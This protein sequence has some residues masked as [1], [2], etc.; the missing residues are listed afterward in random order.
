MIT[1]AIGA[2]KPLTVCIAAEAREN[3]ELAGRASLLR[4][5][6]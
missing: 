4:A 6:E 3:S 1:Y 2:G 5:N